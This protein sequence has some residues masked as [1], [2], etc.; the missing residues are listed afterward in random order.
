[1]AQTSVHVALSVWQLYTFHECSLHIATEMPH[2]T[3]IN[4]QSSVQLDND[5]VASRKLCVK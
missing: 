3:N 4:I 1:M 2:L 5:N